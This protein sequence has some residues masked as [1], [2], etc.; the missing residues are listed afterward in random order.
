MLSIKT[1]KSEMKSNFAKKKA[2]WSFL[3]NEKGCYI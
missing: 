2:H 1:A 3:G